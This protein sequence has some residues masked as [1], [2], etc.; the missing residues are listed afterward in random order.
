VSEQVVAENQRLRILF[1]AAQLAERKGYAASTTGEIMKL[2]GVDGRSFY[3]LFAN[4][5]DAFMAVY[6][7][8]AQQT[9][10]ITAEGFFTGATW[11][12]RL[13]EAGRAFTQFLEIN[14]LIAHVGFVE[15][16]AVG[17]SAVQRVEDSHVA[18]MVFLQ[19]GQQLASERKP[20]RVALEAMITTVFEI[21]YQQSR[22][23]EQPRL[24]P[25]LS[26][27]AALCLTPFLGAAEAE[28]VIDMQA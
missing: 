27:M 12:Q 2:A 1:A 28:R 10:A 19:E 5:Q 3:A 13:W 6:E 20:A 8:G 24:S 17:A 21:V 7:L 16:H 14:P 18:F 11:P 4:K 23:Q 9:L 22:G 26:H 25:L 15:A